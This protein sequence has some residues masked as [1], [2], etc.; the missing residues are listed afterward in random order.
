MKMEFYLYFIFFIFCIVILA[1]LIWKNYWRIEQYTNADLLSPYTPSYF[2]F[3]KN[4]THQENTKKGMIISKN[5]SLIICGLIRD[6]EDKVS[7]IIKRVNLLRPYFKKIK[8]LIVEND[9]KDNTREKLLDWSNKNHAVEILGCG[10]NTKECKMN[11]P[12][13][14]GHGINNSRLQKM[15]LLRNI[16][17]DR[18]EENYS[19]YDYVLA[20][21]MDITGSLYI[22]GIFSTIYHLQNSKGDLDGMCAN[23]LYVWPGMSIYYD[24]FAHNDSSLD[25]TK[26]LNGQ[27][28][29]VIKSISAKMVGGTK[30]VKS[31]FSG[32]TI[33]KV[34]SFL[35]NRYETDG[36]TC[37]HDSISQNLNMMI[38]ENMI[39]YIL[40][41]D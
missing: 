21:D 4:P 16:Y 2:K 23:G 32:A 9:S 20:W 5:S 40:L 19:D 7:D 39:N 33:Y 37:E 28:R 18:I 25:W 11:L 36:T 29:H 31:C 10:L 15:A 12:Q 24:T 22:D 38:N 26:S 30:K 14:V 3:S 41:N 13:T 34:S 35:K 1:I 6:R 27:L 8:V 17:R